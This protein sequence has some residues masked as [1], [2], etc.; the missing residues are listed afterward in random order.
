M[1]TGYTADLEGV[2]FPE[3]ALLRYARAFGALK[4]E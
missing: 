4:E 1:P 3:F 2:A